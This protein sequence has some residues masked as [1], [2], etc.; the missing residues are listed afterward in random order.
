M[1]KGYI[2]IILYVLLVVSCKDKKEDVSGIIK[3]WMGK[4]I[5]F[6]S[7]IQCYSGK[8]TVFSYDSLLNKEFKILLYIDTTDCFK[9]QARLSDWSELI[10]DFN[11][12]YSEKVAF[13]LFYHVKNEQEVCELL[14]YER[15]EYPVVI[16]NKYDVIN[17]LN[18][19]PEHREYQCFLLNKSN[20]VISIGNPTI[21]PGVLNLYKEYINGEK[22]TLFDKRT[23]VDVKK[24]H[25]VGELKINIEK[26]IKIK[27]ENVGMEPFVI[28]GIVASCDCIRVRWNKDPIVDETSVVINLL[29]KEIGSFEN[30]INIHCNTKDSPITICIRG[31]AI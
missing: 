30:T 17:R 21:N 1:K 16:D 14:E 11:L 7:N 6:P 18:N 13:L 22:Q 9:C 26:E 20:R 31:I 25:D 27:V 29:V 5:K 23:K 19:F 28:N 8:N 15:F 10:Y 3:N 12:L 2:V 24:E 4:E